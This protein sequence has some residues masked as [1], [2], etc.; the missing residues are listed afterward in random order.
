[1]VIC[2]SP[3]GNENLKVP[4]GWTAALVE[5]LV[6]VTVIVPGAGFVFPVAEVDP[7]DAAERA[8]RRGNGPPPSTETRPVTSLLEGIAMAALIKSL[9]PMETLITIETLAVVNGDRRPV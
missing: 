5:E 8:I 9:S 1:M 4:S 7:G 2:R 3:V 6:D